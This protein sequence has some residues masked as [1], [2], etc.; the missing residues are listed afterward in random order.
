VDLVAAALERRVLLT[1]PVPTTVTITN[2]IPTPSQDHPAWFTVSINS[3][4][5]GAIPTGT[6]TIE[7]DG[8]A[9]GMGSLFAIDGGAGAYVAGAVLPSAGM[10]QI[11]A[12][13]SGDAE[14]MP[15]TSQPL[16]L[17]VAP[18]LTTL[19]FG[20]APTSVMVG[21]EVQYAVLV[22]AKHPDGSSLGT[23]T[24][25]E[26]NTVV[27]TAPVVAGVPAAV[28]PVIWSTAGFHVVMAYYSGDADDAPAVANGPGVTVT[29]QATTTVVAPSIAIATPGQA[30]TLYA[31]VAAVSPGDATPGGTIVFKNGSVPLGAASLKTIGGKTYAALTTSM[32]PVG[33]DAITAVYYGDANDQPSTSAPTIVHVVSAV[34]TTTLTASPLAPVQG[35]TPVLTAHVSYATAGKGTPTGVVAFS[36]GSRLLAFAPLVPSSIPGVATASYT[37]PQMWPSTYP[38]ADIYGDAAGDLV[39]LGSMTLTVG[40][41]PTRTAL[42]APAAA[43]LGAPVTLTAS[44]TPTVPV[45]MWFNGLVT[46]W[47]GSQPIWGGSATLANGVLTATFTTS[48]LAAGKHVITASYFGEFGSLS[49]TSPAFTITVA[50]AS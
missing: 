12:V 30:V 43:K 45:P 6:V 7:D 34:T 27:G 47:D 4:P 14:D 41:V 35:Q 31:A 42:S 21:T 48:P 10:R 16:A 1:A 20:E 8:V 25:K 23:I 49:S 15:S 13:Y 24:L 26:G 46:F 5:P 22:G 44:I 11:T 19:T 18:D 32:L 37:L 50:P 9:I 17:A 40:D 39:S 38:F 33:P 2:A 29:P 28:V 36:T 3:V